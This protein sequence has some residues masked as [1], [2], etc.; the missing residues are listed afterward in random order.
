MSNAKTT[1]E[2]I[3]AYLK[4]RTTIEE[5]YAKRLTRLG[6]YPLSTVEIGTAKKSLEVL[7]AETLVMA[8]THTSAASR[9]RSEVEEPHSSLSSIHR[10]KRKQLQAGVE[11]LFKLKLQQQ[12]DAKRLKER[13]ESDCQKVNGLSAQQ[14]LLLGREL[15]K[16]NNKLE[17]IQGS[18]MASKAEYQHATDV[19]SETS[20][21]WKHEWT[22]ACNAFQDLEEERLDKLKVTLWTY[23]NAL[24]QVCVSDDEACERLRLCLESCDVQEDIQSFISTSGTGGQSLSASSRREVREPRQNGRSYETAQ[25]NRDV[26]ADTR[27]SGQGAMQQDRY[28]QNRQPAYNQVGDDRQNAVV[29]EYPLDGITQ[30]CRSDSAATSNSAVSATASSTYSSIPGSIR[31]TPATSISSQSNITPVKQEPRRKSFMER[32]ESGWPVARAGSPSNPDGT[33]PLKAQK[34]GGSMF[35]ALRPARSRSRASSRADSRL[36]D[37][38]DH[39]SSTLQDKSDRSSRYG[40]GDPIAGALARLSVSSRQDVRGADSYSSRS[41]RDSM[42]NEFARSTEHVDH[43][44]SVNGAPYQ[45]SQPKHDAYATRRDAPDREIRADRNASSRTITSA[46]ARSHGPGDLRRTPSPNPSNTSSRDTRSVSSVRG[47]D[48]TSTVPAE[49]A[50]RNSSAT[51]PRSYGRSGYTDTTSHNNTSR[52]RHASTEPDDVRRS[53]RSP[54]PMYGDSRYDPSRG[55]DPV[56]SRDRSQQRSRSRSSVATHKSDNPMTADGVSIKRFVVALYDYQAAIPE[57]IGFCA[58]DTVAVLEMRPDGWWIGEVAGIK[59]AR[60]GL[61]PSNFFKSA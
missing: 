36:S 60:R 42:P 3:K 44:R 27:S 7:Q 9:L 34:T 61:V 13:Y 6:K 4:E 35:D 40:N 18:L 39:S 53:S 30:L 46:P 11:K 5:E 12:A 48:R 19:L 10:E 37:R 25:A 26:R 49:S 29:N 2:Q 56:V 28:A 32:V 57:E 43:S 15:E 22:K 17:K 52:S 51:S 23:A 55:R 8:E 16:N 1:S 59:N 21:K 33:R 50:Q 54:I 31:H 58:G 24:S 14:N 45:A 38:L 20:D 41:S 47:N